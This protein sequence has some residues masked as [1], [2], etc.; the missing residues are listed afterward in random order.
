[1]ADAGPEPTY[2]EKMKVPP[3]PG[4]GSDRRRNNGSDVKLELVGWCLMLVFGCANRSFSTNNQGSV[5]HIRVNEQT[6]NCTCLLKNSDC[7]S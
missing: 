6:L 1:M 4:V 2:A 3:P 5:H 7:I